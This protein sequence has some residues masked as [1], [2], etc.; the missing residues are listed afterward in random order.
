MRRVESSEVANFY[1]KIKQEGKQ[2]HHKQCSPSIDSLIFLSSTLMFFTLS[3]FILNLALL[4][5]G[6]NLLTVLSSLHHRGILSGHF[7]SLGYHSKTA[8]IH[9]NIYDSCTGP[10]ICEPCN[11]S[12]SVGLLLSIPLIESPDW[13]S[14]VVC[15][16]LFNTYLWL[17]ILKLEKKESVCVCILCTHVFHSQI[18]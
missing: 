8:W 18:T 11:V 15:W 9:L 13:R 14:T 12:S 1:L 17:K 7:S 10:R 4:D 3:A 16:S 6:L 2:I 5:I